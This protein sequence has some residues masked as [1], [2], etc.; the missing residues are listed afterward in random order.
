MKQKVLAIAAV[1]AMAAT[2]LTLVHA[3]GPCYVTT[4]PNCS[5]YMENSY[6]QCPDEYESMTYSGGATVNK[7]TDAASGSLGCWE[8]EQIQCSYTVTVK[9][10]DGASDSQNHTANGNT[11]EKISRKD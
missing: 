9:W 5:A 6:G 10:C 4:T 2:G 3:A 1:S 7:C 11:T 8:R